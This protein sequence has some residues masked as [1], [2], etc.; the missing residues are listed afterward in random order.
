MALLKIKNVRIA[1]MS[2]GVPKQVVRNDESPVG[3]VKM[4]IIK[5]L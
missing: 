5:I 3:G 1:G 2:A 4:L